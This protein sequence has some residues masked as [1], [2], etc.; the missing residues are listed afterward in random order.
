[1]LPVLAYLGLRPED[2]SISYL[3]RISGAWETFKDLDIEP[4]MKEVDSG[5]VLARQGIFDDDEKPKQIGDQLGSPELMAKLRPYTQLRNRLVK[6][7]A[8]FVGY[9]AK[10]ESAFTKPKPEEAIVS[11]E[12]FEKQL[13]MDREALSQVRDLVSE[14][15]GNLRHPGTPSSSQALVYVGGASAFGLLVYGIYR[16]IRRSTESDSRGW[17]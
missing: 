9:K 3:S 7:Y 12:R 10:F 1:M 2:E 15:P 17:Q 14:E 8:D 16:L 5:A 11:L 13:R 4:F 6:S